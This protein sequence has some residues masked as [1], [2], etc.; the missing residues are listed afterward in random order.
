MDPSWTS[1]I[2]TYKIIRLYIYQ[3]PYQSNQMLNYYF[4][5]KLFLLLNLQFR[6]QHNYIELNLKV[7]HQ[8]TQYKYSTLYLIDNFTNILYIMYYRKDG[9]IHKTQQLRLIILP[10]F[11]LYTHIYNDCLKDQ[12]YQY[13]AQICQRIQDK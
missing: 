2:K 7:N 11:F 13:P 6:H 4:Y 9:V 10:W 1:S 12:M 8:V 3:Y 5:V